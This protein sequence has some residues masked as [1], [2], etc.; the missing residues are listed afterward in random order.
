MSDPVVTSP[1]AQ[2]ARRSRR[3]QSLVEFALV[4]PMLLVLLLGIVDFG[5]VFQAGIVTEAAARDGAE[6]GALERLRADPPSTPADYERL[7]RIAAQAACGETRVLANTTYVAD[8]PSTPAVDEEAC[9][10]MPIIAVC[11]QDGGDPN[12]GG[13]APGYV[14]TPPAECTEF[15]RPWDG[16]SGGATGS[17]SVEV[18]LCYRFTTLL[19]L[20]MSFPWVGWGLSL[21]DIYLQRTRAF[22]VDCAPGD[23]SGC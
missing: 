3:G 1:T 22:V 14:G 19:N 18:R 11:V 9:P 8:N 7:H 15:S 2:L 12:C 16:A 20:H 21:G 4:V 23:P 13:L 6:A 10:A 5:R 17:H